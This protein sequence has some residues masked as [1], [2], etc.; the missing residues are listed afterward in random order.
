MKTQK[1]EKVSDKALNMYSASKSGLESDV[2]RGDNVAGSLLYCDDCRKDC[3][4]ASDNTVDRV[5]NNTSLK[6]ENWR[7]PLRAD[8]SVKP[9]QVQSF[10]RVIEKYLLAA[11][12]RGWAGGG[13]GEGLY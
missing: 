7:E 11:E 2:W 1:L 3:F 5:I 9:G 6:I 12:K 8:N 4:K 13:V 10:S